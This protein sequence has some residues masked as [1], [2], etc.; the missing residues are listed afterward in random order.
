MAE[1]GGRLTVVGLGPGG[2]QLLTPA[3]QAAVID[4]EVVAGYGL[5]VDLVRDLVAGKEILVTGMR[6]ERE[7]V[8]AAIDAAEAGRSVALVCSGDAGV[9]GMA[10]LALEV[11]ASRESEVPFAAVPGVTAGL[12]AAALLGAPLAHD[13][14]IISL[15]DLLTPLER[16]ESR[17]RHAAAADL[18]L[19]LYNPAGKSRREPLAR[20]VCILREVCGPERLVGRV[21][22]AY[23]PGQEVSIHTV[24]TLP[25]DA[26][27]MLTLLVVGNSQTY[28][29]RD[30]LITPRGYRS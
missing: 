9:F 28:R 23:R 8:V 17:V 12:A 30:W 27:D 2:A 29:W 19:A 16:I 5:Y 4:C 13:H 1:Q 18:A 20:A 26:V 24:A 7:R 3:G 22:N 10:S 25:Q 6:R 15:S 14:A 11:L 21:R